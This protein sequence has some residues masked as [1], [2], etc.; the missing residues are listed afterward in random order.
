MDWII[1]GTLIPARREDPDA[2]QAQISAMFLAGGM[3]RSQV[4]AA[5][6]LE[7]HAVQNWVKRGFLSPPVGKRQGRGAEREGRVFRS[8][9]ADG[10]QERFRYPRLA[11]WGSD[12]SD[13]SRQ[14]LFVRKEG[15]PSF[16]IGNFVENLVIR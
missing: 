4:A 8:L 10:V 6:G 7:A 9:S 16:E 5:P 12:V 13:I 2:A 15:E 3:V 11:E 14:V 1:P